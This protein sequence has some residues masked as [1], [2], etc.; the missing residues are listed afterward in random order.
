MK[1]G[2][3]IC[4]LVCLALLAPVG[5]VQAGDRAA[6]NHRTGLF[7]PSV[8]ELRKAAERGDR[9]ELA[10]AAGRLGPARLAKALTDPDRRVVLAALDGLPQVESGI[11][12]LDNVLAV[13]ASTDQALRARAVHTVASLLA[14]HDPASLGE[15]EVPDETLQATCQVL[16]GVAGKEGEQVPTRLLAIQGLL[17]VGAT[18]V[19][20]IKPTLLLASPEPEIRRATVLFLLPESA[21]NDSFLAAARD[22]DPCVAAAA[23]VRLCKRR[24]KGKALPSQPPLRQLA[25]A[26]GA[27]PEDV[28]EMLPCLIA[29]TDP[30]DR[31]A[32]NELRTSGPAAVRDALK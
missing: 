18:C 16:V 20:G 6:V 13:V 14:G 21:S 17:D 11:L 1:N 4:T 31:K 28:I 27:A 10:R 9:T 26:P 19:A 32:V 5:T 15:W 24:S 25:M 3:F 23:G 7:E 12:V 22:S 8:T 2:V 30:E 29:G